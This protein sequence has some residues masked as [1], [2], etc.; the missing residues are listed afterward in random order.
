LFSVVPMIRRL[1]A[2]SALRRR[3]ARGFGAAHSETLQ[4]KN[5]GRCMRR[6][7]RLSLRGSG[8]SVLA[9]LLDDEAPATAEHVW[10]RL[11]IEGQL[12]HAHNS[13]AEVFI[14]L[15]DPVRLPAENLVRLPLPGELLYF[16]Q[17][18]ENA[19][20]ASAPIGE[21]AFIYGRGVTLR[22]AEGVPTHLNLFARVPGDWKYDWRPFADGC[23]AARGAPL[24]LRIERADPESG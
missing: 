15:D 17:G 11:P 4:V 2:S 24:T 20:A 14:L 12:V 10:N 22:A 21:I 6:Q 8:A 5:R 9:D 7:L 18:T 16:Y 1:V 23:R 13:G 19:T 3:V